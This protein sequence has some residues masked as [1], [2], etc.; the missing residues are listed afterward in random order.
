MEN[1]DFVAIDLETAT[2]HRNSICEIGIAIVKNSE[3][4]ESKSWLVKPEDNRYDYFNI[5]IH[6]ITPEMTEYAPPFPI[7]WKEVETYL[8]NNVVVAHNSSFDM[9]VL[10]D[11]FL[12]NNMPFPTFK[13]F[14]SY[15]TAK[16]IVKGCSSYSLPN[17]CEALT[18]PFGTHHR[19]EG[20][21]IGCANVFIKCLELAEIH[22]LEEL[23][24]KYNFRCGE[25]TINSF[26]PQ[27]TRSSKS[28]SIS[29][30]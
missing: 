22:S 3:I 9:Y 27:S 26:T 18:I 6:H 10:K 21:S 23:Q 12:A 4:I 16:Y 19:A 2:S 29:R 17:I 25:F 11:T 1:L 14:C 28:K 20:D 8:T 7:V 13:H 5:C 15:R 30:F 24:D